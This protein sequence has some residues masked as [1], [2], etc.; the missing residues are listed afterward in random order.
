MMNA[1]FAALQTLERCRRDGA[2]SGRVLD[3]L[4]GSGELDRN[5][6]ALAAN[7][8]IGVLQNSAFLD[9]YIDSFSFLTRSRRM[10]RSMKPCPC[11]MPAGLA[12]LR[13][14]SMPC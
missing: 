9:Y 8:S 13:G 5:E 1:R 6:A 4:S 10:P 11:A 14:L 7:L 2:W 12:E 3:R